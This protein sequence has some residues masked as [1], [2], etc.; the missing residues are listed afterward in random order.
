MKKTFRLLAAAALG[1]PAISI[2]GP[3]DYVT[4]PAIEYGEREIDFKMG[5]EKARDSQ[6]GGKESAASLGFGYGARQWWF[7]EAYIKYERLPGEGTRFDAFEWENKFQLTEPNQYFADLGFLT[8]IEVPRNRDEGYEIRFGPLVQLDTGAVRWN[9]NLLFERFV[10]SR[11]EGEHPLEMGYQLQAR[12]SLHPALDVGVQAFGDMGKWNHWEPRDEQNHR[13]GPAVFG[14]VK[15]GG[16]EAIVYN[17]ALLFG[18]SDGAPKNT[19]RLQA[20]YEF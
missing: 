3:S 18:L 8:E 12:Y 4:T 2:A 19:F 11:E 14:K 7:T 10:R 6:G 9:A 1:L 5:T 17:A 13:A 20:E 16:R 15:L